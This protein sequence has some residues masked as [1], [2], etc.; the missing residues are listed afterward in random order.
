MFPLQD[1]SSN[2]VKPLFYT[3][4]SIPPADSGTCLASEPGLSAVVKPLDAVT[5]AFCRDQSTGHDLH[6]Q[7]FSAITADINPGQRW[8]L[9][10]CFIISP[11]RSFINT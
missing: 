8:F 9:G 3:L 1:A 7:D 10:I 6:N 11:G 2:S 4:K 5:F